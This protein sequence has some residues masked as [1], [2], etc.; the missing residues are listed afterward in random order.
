MSKRLKLLYSSEAYIW[1]VKTHPVKPL[2]ALELRNESRHEVSFAV[3]DFQHEKVIREDIVFQEQWWITLKDV[4]DEYLVLQTFS[5]YN[6]PANHSTLV[7][8]YAVGELLVEI[9]NAGYES[10]VGSR[11]LKVVSVQDE[12]VKTYV[13]DVLTGS[14]IVP[15]R[16]KQKKS[17]IQIPDFPQFYPINHPYFDMVRTFCQQK[18]NIQIVKGCDYLEFKEGLI[19]SYYCRSEQFLKNKL[20]IINNDFEIIYHEQLGDELNG[21]SEDTFFTLYPRLFFIKERKQ[22]F[23]Y[24]L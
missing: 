24:V 5:D 7:F 13:Y 20:V 19:I 3:V 17:K 1:R 22:L 21:I 18:L 2:V 15:P 4:V 8:D 12:E 6:N 16:H 10:F 14:E 9:E 23:S 11:A